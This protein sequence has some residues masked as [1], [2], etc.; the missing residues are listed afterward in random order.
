VTAGTPGS[1]LSRV[2]IEPFNLLIVGA[3]LVASVLPATG[4]TAQ[5]FHVASVLAVVLLFFW[6]GAKLSPQQ[7]RAGLVHGRLHAAV[8]AATYGIFPVL[9]IVLK[10]LGL[11]LLS[12]STYDG[13][14]YLC[15]SPST[16]QTSVVFVSLARGNVPAALCAASLSSLA[17]VVLTPLW[18]R[19]L[20]VGGS[21]HA[22]P[23]SAAWDLLLQLVLPLLLG[24]LAR[25]WIGA[26]VERHRALLRQ[27][28]QLTIV[29]VVYVA[30]SH[31]VAG[32]LW[33]AL[34]PRSFLTLAALDAVILATV[35]VATTWM[36]RALGFSKEDEITVVFCG[37]K[38]GLASGAAIANVLFARD[39]VGVLLIPLMVFHQLQLMVAAALAHRYARRPS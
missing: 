25:R 36:S 18:L 38:K 16:I 13:V 32:G 8:F 9:A 19:I 11:L 2:P 27:Y 17:G 33:Q 5:A 1:W 34:S 35:M 4:A 7:L 3:V 21:E 28:D 26:W 20:G 6:Q 37:S 15:T 22:V 14:I 29:L 39:V 12:A 10:P 23:W 24:Q 30:F 31:A